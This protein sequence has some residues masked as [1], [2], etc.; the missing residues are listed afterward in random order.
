MIDNRVERIWGDAVLLQQVLI[1]LVKNA[2][3]ARSEND[4]PCVWLTLTSQRR[5]DEENVLIEIIDNG[6]GIANIDNLF[7]PFYTTKKRG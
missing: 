4:E 7:V 3:E 1:N 5:R 6:Q 2:L